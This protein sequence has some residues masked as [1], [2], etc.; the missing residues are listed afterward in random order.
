MSNNKP[1]TE[2]GLKTVLKEIG[3]ATKKD[4]K[5]FATKEDLLK[6][7]RRLKRYDNKNKREI[8]HALAKLAVT[9]PTLQAF[10]ELKGKVKQSFSVS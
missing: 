3:V 7:E 9:T 5:N 4:L 6:L 2:A 8:I 1:L 10:E